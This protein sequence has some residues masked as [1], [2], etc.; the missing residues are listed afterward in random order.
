MPY[1]NKE[2]ARIN[3]NASLKRKVA[4]SGLTLHAYR[5]TKYP[6]YFG[7]HRLICQ[8]RKRSI[9][10][11]IQ[12]TIKSADLK[13]ILDAQKGVCPLTGRPLRFGPGWDMTNASIDRIDQS[14]GYIASNVRLVCWWA[15]IA[16]NVMTDEESF[17]WCRLVVVFNRRKRA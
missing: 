3:R 13:G 6:V 7:L 2:A 1:K 10:K 17:I 15:N 4:A 16:R 12:F 14:L 9:A 11:G 8:N 5:K